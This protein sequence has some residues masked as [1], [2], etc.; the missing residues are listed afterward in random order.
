MMQSDFLCGIWGILGN[1]FKNGEAGCGALN[2][3]FV[4]HGACR[5][6]MVD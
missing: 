6:L 3:N 1:Y 5:I 2:I 4:T